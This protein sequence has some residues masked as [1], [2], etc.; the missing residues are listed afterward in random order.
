MARRLENWLKSAI[1]SECRQGEN[2]C[3][4]LARKC[5]LSRDG[6]GSLV[7][8]ASA[9][10]SGESAG[11]AAEKPQTGSNTEDGKDKECCQTAAACWK[12]YAKLLE[13]EID[14]KNKK[15]RRSGQRRR[16]S[17]R[18]RRRGR[19]RSAK[20]RGFPSRPIVSIAGTATKG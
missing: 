6:V 18:I 11:L 9:E 8:R 10:R 3:K 17:G 4:A 16:Q 1:I 7:L 14:G 13:A 2:G 5:H 19:G 12:N 20:S 15:N